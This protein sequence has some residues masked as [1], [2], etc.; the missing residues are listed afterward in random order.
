MGKKTAN[1]AR[2]PL[3]MLRSSMTDVEA[4]HKWYSMILSI[5]ETTSEGRG[6][7]IMVHN[8]NR[9]FLKKCDPKPQ[10]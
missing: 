2:K 7:A 6:Q 9:F 8:Y 1:T 4:T 5:K 3:S 10:P